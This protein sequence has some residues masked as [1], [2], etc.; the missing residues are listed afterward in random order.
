MITMG[1]KQYEW[2]LLHAVNG[3]QFAGMVEVPA[4]LK[5]EDKL[6]KRCLTAD[7]MQSKVDVEVLPSAKHHGV[8]KTAD[9]VIE[10]RNPH[11]VMIQVGQG[12]QL[13][14]VLPLNVGDRLINL[15][16]SSILYSQ[17]LDDK[18]PIILDIR[19]ASAGIVAPGDADEQKSGGGIILPGAAGAKP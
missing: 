6:Y 17:F 19:K 3:E 12:Q 15:R 18:S 16:A 10:L 7:L 14:S 13:I 8:E 1:D 2:V 5:Q 9:R 4:D 11:Q